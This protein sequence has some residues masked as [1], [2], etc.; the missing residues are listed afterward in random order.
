[1]ESWQR[2]LFVHSSS[3]CLADQECVSTWHIDDRHATRP[4]A[5]R[6]LLY[7]P[8]ASS[9]NGLVR[10]KI[11][12]AIQFFALARKRCDDDTQRFRS[13]S[14]ILQKTAGIGFRLVGLN[15]NR[16]FLGADRSTALR[17]AQF[18][19][20]CCCLRRSRYLPVSE[21]QFAKLLTPRMPV[22][23]SHLSCLALVSPLDGT[24]IGK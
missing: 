12:R 22:M 4:T 23:R 16:A 13:S 10:E 1:M 5:E 3:S 14:R 6:W 20:A 7:L 15:K 2:T 18:H 8:I 21:W 24:W 11:A 9:E 17:T 19:V